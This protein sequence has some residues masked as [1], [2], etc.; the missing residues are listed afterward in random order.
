[1]YYSMILMTMKIRLLI[2]GTFFLIVGIGIGAYLIHTTQITSSIAQPSKIQIV[3]AESVWG[4]IASQIGGTE[5]R[6]ISIVSDPNADPHEY[7]ATTND[8]RAFASAKYVIVNGVGYDSWATTLLT[9][10][11]NPSQKVLTVGD[12]IGKKE[13]DNPHLWYSPAYVNAA[14]KQM[15]IDLIALDPAHK[16]VY[17]AN[18]ETLQHSLAEYQDRIVSIAH[19]YAGTKVASTEDVFAYLATAAGLDLVS[20]PAFTEAVAEGNDPPAQ[21][22]VEFQNQLKTKQ[23]SVLVYNE[24]TITPLTEGMK[25][26]AA[27]EGIPVV[28]ITE[29]IQPANTSFQ[30]WMNAELINLENALHAKSLGR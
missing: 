17:E 12:L 21:S 6:V 11:K 18:Y 30:D 19:Q 27:D 16:A 15:E 4:S 20:P 26:L 13:G 7:E 2:A 14:A 9:A 28:G 1:M 23:V 8:A 25:K 29:T 22:V 10:G 3:A 24:Q 5:V